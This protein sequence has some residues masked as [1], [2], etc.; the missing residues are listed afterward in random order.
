MI[1]PR[2]PIV[3]R[4]HPLVP[5]GS[6]Y[7]LTSHHSEQLIELGITDVDLTVE[8]VLLLHPSDQREF[9]QEER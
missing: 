5:R 6:A 9:E 2:R 8:D 3:T 7:T 1:E 4:T